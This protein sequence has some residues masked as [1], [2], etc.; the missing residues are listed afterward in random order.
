MPLV[1]DNEEDIQELKSD[2]SDL[3]TA[4]NTQKNSIN[5]L[6]TQMAVA[7]SNISN[8][9]SN[10]TT[11]TSQM[12]VANSN[13]TNNQSNITN[14]NTRV[15]N[16]EN[17]INNLTTQQT[18]TTANVN[19]LQSNVQNF[20][21]DL[22]QNT[23]QINTINNNYTLLER[24]V[25]TLEDTPGGGSSSIPEY[26]IRS[27]VSPIS[28]VYFNGRNGANNKLLLRFFNP[29]PIDLHNK[30][31]AVAVKEIGTSDVK[32]YTATECFSGYIEGQKVYGFTKN[33]TL[34]TTTSSF[35]KNA[36]CYIENYTETNDNGVWGFGLNLPGN[37][38]NST[39]Y[40]ENGNELICFYDNTDNSI[41]GMY[42]VTVDIELRTIRVEKDNVLINNYN[43]NSFLEQIG[44]N[45]LY[46]AF[47]EY[48][49][50]G[51][52][53]FQ[54]QNQQP[55]NDDVV[56]IH[57]ILL[58]NRQE[59]YGSWSFNYNIQN[60]HMGITT[61]DGNT[62]DYF[63]ANPDPEQWFAC[64]NYQFAFMLRYDPGQMTESFNFNFDGINTQ[65]YDGTQALSSMGGSGDLFAYYNE[66]MGGIGGSS[67]YFSSKNNT[68]DFQGQTENVREFTEFM[69]T[70]P[71]VLFWTNKIDRSVDTN[72]TF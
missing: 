3:K 55:S 60:G 61:P 63:I 47:P 13:I 44:G 19:L 18:A 31:K 28:D 48:E 4:V 68:L 45:A 2:V 57:G 46:M 52:F 14:L 39:V 40:E 71:P 35:N 29:L 54:I 16:C 38:T 58:K 64:G 17:N 66:S 69:S 1:N 72:F 15:T 24:R 21:I 41:N 20:A 33:N 32:L 67:V 70:V 26:L 23:G 12:A 7:N 30:L 10:V 6:N 65:Y 34:I 22:L 62:Y 36:L 9:Q 43:T 42:T 8:V 50:N 56:M 49:K 25:K 37:V 59:Y 27:T 11:L 5:T 53:N 51:T